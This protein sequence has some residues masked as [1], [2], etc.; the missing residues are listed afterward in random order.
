M[1]LTILKNVKGISC[2]EFLQR[3]MIINSERYCEI[4]WL[5][6]KCTWKIKPGWRSV[7]FFHT[8]SQHKAAIQLTNRSTKCAVFAHFPYSFNV[9]ASDSWLFLKLKMA[10][11]IFLLSEV[12]IFMCN[13]IKSQIFSLRQNEKVDKMFGNIYHIT[14]DYAE[15]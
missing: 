1:I 9:S 13:W 2:M 6:K 15:K 12:E 14:Y 5:L 10:S 11:K 3:W 7:F 8:L 4:L